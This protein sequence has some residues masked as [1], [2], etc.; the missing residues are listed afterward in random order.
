[1]VTTY[2]EATVHGTAATPEIL[3][4]DELRTAWVFAYRR[5]HPEAGCWAVGF[6]AVEHSLETQER[7]F[8]MVEQLVARTASRASIFAALRRADAVAQGGNGWPHPGAP[9][10]RHLYLRGR[11]VRGSDYPRGPWLNSLSAAAA[12]CEAID[13]LLGEHGIVVN[14][15]PR[16]AFDEELRRAGRG[17]VPRPQVGRA[18][19]LLDRAPLIDRLHVRGFDPITF[20]GTDP[21]AFAWV[22]FELASRTEAATTQI[23]CECHPTFRPIPL[24]VAVDRSSRSLIN[25]RLVTVAVSRGSV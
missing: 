19:I 16:E 6:G 22:I 2:L 13:T 1:V 3:T 23:R 7:V 12:G 18:I 4:L 25:P 17:W 5:D 21:A 20:D 11:E 15:L 8:R 10:A 24:D 14:L 9:Q